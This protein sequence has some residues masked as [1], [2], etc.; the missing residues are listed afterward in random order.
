M[1]KTPVA[2]TLEEVLEACERHI[3]NKAFEYWDYM[4]C[5]DA[6][7][8]ELETLLQTRKNWEELADDVR[9]MLKAK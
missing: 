1:R 5:G 2:T 3:Q 6:T 7:P 4:D 8:G 9:A